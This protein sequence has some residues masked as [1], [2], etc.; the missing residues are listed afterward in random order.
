MR[1][2][3]TRPLETTGLVCPQVGKNPLAHVDKLLV[4][5]YQ[6]RDCPKVSDLD[7]TVEENSNR[8]A[9]VERL[10]YIIIGM[11]AVEFGV[12]LI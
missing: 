10:L 12:M 5:P 8:L 2:G 4:C 11:L 9:N 6:D 7:R 1:S 3:S